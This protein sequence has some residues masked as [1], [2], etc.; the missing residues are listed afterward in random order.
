[1]TK[2]KRNLS[3]LSYIVRVSIAKA[4]RKLSNAMFSQI[5]S[6]V[7][8][9]LRRAYLLNFLL[10]RLPASSSA[11]RVKNNLLFKEEESEEKKNVRD[12]F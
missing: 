9:S 1:M 12:S 10:K 6:D 4:L 7:K 11:Q 3:N 2:M 8:Y 5:I